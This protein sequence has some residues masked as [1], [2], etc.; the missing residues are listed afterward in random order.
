MQS[1]ET[2]VEFVCPECKTTHRVNR[3][4]RIEVDLKETVMNSSLFKWD[5]PECAH[6]VKLIYP[7]FYV[8]NS[9][10]YVVWL[11]PNA[12]DTTT[13]D[14]SLVNEY[15]GYTKRLCTTLD[16]FVE[17]V[18]ILDSGL[19]DQAIELLKLITFAKVHISNDEIEHIYFYRKNEASNLELTLMYKEDVDGIEIPDT[20]YQSVLS[21]VKEELEP[22]G[23]DVFLIDQEWAGGKVIG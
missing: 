21:I 17:K 14:R 4:D 13:I 20:M 11:V 12:S 23:D 5:C 22:L 19:Q 7:C 2:Q 9:K 3:Y 15:E 8:D 1:Q 6:K 16:S 18:R 10:R